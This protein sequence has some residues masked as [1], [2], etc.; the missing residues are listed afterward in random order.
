MA[1]GAEYNAEAIEVLTGL[2]PVRVTVEE[3]RAAGA[4][5]LVYEY[6]DTKFSGTLKVE[7]K[8]VR[9]AAQTVAFHRLDR[10]TLISHLEAR[11]VVQG[12]GLQKIQVALPESAGTNLG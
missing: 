1:I 5:R 11:M 4:P 12:G 7:R 3:Q 10:E 2:D 9:V 8:P 6:Q